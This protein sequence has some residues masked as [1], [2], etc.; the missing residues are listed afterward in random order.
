MAKKYQS[1]RDKIDKL[2]KEKREAANA[3]FEEETK[4]LFSKYLDLVSFSWRQYT[5]YF[6]DGDTCYFHVYGEYPRLVLAGEDEAI[7]SDDFSYND[8]SEEAQYVNRISD[9]IAFLLNAIDPG[10]MKDLF[11]D[12]V[13]ITVS[14]HDGV[15]GRDYSSHD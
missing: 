12:H 9:E 4:S 7:S 13:E 8:N 15:S 3:L 10:D 2:R 14:R 1:F 6:N 11:G 5:P